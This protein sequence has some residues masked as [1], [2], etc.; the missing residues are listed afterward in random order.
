MIALNALC[1][2][3]PGRKLGEVVLERALSSLKP[4]KQPVHEQP[5]KKAIVEVTWE[6]Y[7]F[8]VC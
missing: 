6:L 4:M 7:S 3:V 1:K 2:P 8:K 5:A